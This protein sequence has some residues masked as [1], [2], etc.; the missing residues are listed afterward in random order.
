MDLSFFYLRGTSRYTEYKH[1]LNHHS[2]E[3]PT[4]I[5]YRFVYSKIASYSPCCF[6]YPYRLR[7]ARFEPHQN[8]V[9]AYLAVAD[10]VFGKDNTEDAFVGPPVLNP[11]KIDDCYRKEAYNKGQCDVAVGRTEVKVVYIELHGGCGAL[12]ANETAWSNHWAIH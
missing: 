6:R 10:L 4:E 8:F 5:I 7:R 3:L 12:E 9:S 2:C 1:P 11:K